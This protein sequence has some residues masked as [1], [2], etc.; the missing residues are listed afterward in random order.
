MFLPHTIKTLGGSDADGPFK[1]GRVIMAKSA[2]ALLEADAYQQY[3]EDLRELAKMPVRHFDA[4]YLNLI[5]RFAEFVQVL[6]CYEQREVGGLLHDGLIRAR[7]TLERI[8]DAEG[9]DVAFQRGYAFYSAALLKKVWQAV[10]NMQIDICSETGEHQKL[11]NPI[12]ETL[13]EA[14]QYFRIRYTQGDPPV[15][16][17]LMNPILARELM[18]AVGM[19]W[20]AQRRGLLTMWLATLGEEGVDS[21]TLGTILELS[22]AYVKSQRE[23]MNVISLTSTDVPETQ[24]GEAFWRWLK[25]G[26]EAGTVAVNTP[27]AAVHLVENGILLE[28]ERLIKDFCK[29]YSKYRDWVVVKQQFNMLGLAP[30]SGFDYKHSQYYSDAPIKRARK[31]NQAK[32]RIAAYSPMFAISKQTTAAEQALTGDLSSKDPSQRGAAAAK[33]PA[34][35]SISGALITNPYLIYPR[36]ATPQNS[37]HM[38]EIDPG[39]VSAVLL[40]S[41]EVNNDFDPT[42]EPDGGLFS[43]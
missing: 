7:F 34:A 31:S 39:L 14:G 29:V 13:I 30:L 35:T 43:G 24:A 40:P 4:L 3:F 1:E 28:L 9:E 17:S 18:P 37:P 2:K 11:W 33:N 19:N 41:L 36:K 32:G 6:P 8:L 16:A 38:I 12:A 20:I 23:S 25:Q 21:G 5:H 42:P 27:E 22:E 15:L 10:L 26:I